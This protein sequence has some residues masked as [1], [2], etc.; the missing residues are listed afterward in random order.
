MSQFCMTYLYSVQSSFFHGSLKISGFAN[1]RQTSGQDFADG[2]SANATWHIQKSRWTLDCST[3]W[4]FEPERGLSHWHHEHL[5]EPHLPSITSRW[6][7]VKKQ[8]TRL[9][10]VVCCVCV[11]FC[12]HFLRKS[13]SSNNLALLRFANLKFELRIN[14]I[15]FIFIPKKDPCAELDV[16]FC[17]EFLL[18]AT[19]GPRQHGHCGRPRS[20]AQDF[21]CF[22]FPDLHTHTHQDAPRAGQCPASSVSECHWQQESRS[23]MNELFPSF[24]SW[25]ANNEATLRGQQSFF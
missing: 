10:Y 7:N 1:W 12:E 20:V 18:L 8:E 3:L 25:E 19:K 13:R 22:R 14:S 23:V 11:E 5:Q 4:S 21:T 17:H 16:I 2:H 9:P 6:R 15:F 24:S